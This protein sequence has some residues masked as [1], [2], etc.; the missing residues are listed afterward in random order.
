MNPAV[1]LLLAILGILFYSRSTL[2]MTTYTTVNQALAAKIHTGTP[3]IDRLPLAD[4]ITA[5][6]GDNVDVG[7]ARACC[8]IVYK[9]SGG[10]PSQYLGDTGIASGPSIGPMQVLR[11][12]AISLG[13]VDADTTP[14]QYAA[15]KNNEDAGCYNGCRVFQDA[16]TQAS[17]NIQDA[18]AV[19]NGGPARPASALAYADDAIAW[20]GRTYGADWQQDMVAAADVAPVED[21]P[22]VGDSDNTDESEA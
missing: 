12:T 16:M 21:A 10:N 7:T 22:V 6:F 8:A 18:L 1:L 4:N 13:L 17:N 3:R 20:L 19:Y 15:M 11:A 14:A 9:E 5:V 2:G